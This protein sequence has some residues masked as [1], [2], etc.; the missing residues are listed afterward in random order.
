MLQRGEVSC[1]GGTRIGGA[2][3]LVCERGSK[4]DTEEVKGAETEGAERCGRVS[5]TGVCVPV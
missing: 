2:P 1:P 3:T 5:W 4:D